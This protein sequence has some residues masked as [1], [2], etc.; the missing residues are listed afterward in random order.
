MPCRILIQ[1]VINRY[2]QIGNL[3]RSGDGIPVKSIFIISQFMLYKDFP[4]LFR[5]ML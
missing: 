4:L 2:R 5:D 1:E 3:Y